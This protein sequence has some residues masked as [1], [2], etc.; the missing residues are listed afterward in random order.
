[1]SSNV[2]ITIRHVHVIRPSVTV[3]FSPHFDR[4]VPS[5]NRLILSLN[6]D[7]S[8][9]FSRFSSPTVET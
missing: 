4:R 7:Q 8:L 5:D 1:M 9:D 2:I 3:V 6:Y